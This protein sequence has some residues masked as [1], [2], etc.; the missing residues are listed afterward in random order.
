[1]KKYPRSYEFTCGI[2]LGLVTIPLIFLLEACFKE[3]DSFPH[4]KKWTFMFYDD[5]DF[6]PQY[7]RFYLFKSAMC[8][9]ENVNV[10]VLRDIHHGPARYY[11]ID[12]DHQH[13]LKKELGEIN[14]GSYSSLY[15]FLHY[16]KENYPAER[17]ILSLYNHGGGWIG[18]C[19]DFTDNHDWLS[20]DDMQI[21]LRKAGGVDLVFFSGVCLM[22]TVETAY[23]LRDCADAYVASENR[24]TYV[25]WYEPMRD[26]CHILNST[27]EISTFEFA[28]TVVDLI[29]NSGSEIL[30]FGQGLTMSAVRMDKM[31]DLIQGIDELSLKYLDNIGV[32]CSHISTVFRDVQVY[33]GE[34]IDL[35][36]LTQELLK[37]EKDTLIRNKLE[38]VQECLKEAVIAECH[39]DDMDGSHGLSIYFPASDST[40][41]NSFYNADDFS[42]DFARTSHWD[43]LLISYFGMIKRKIIKVI[44]EPPRTHLYE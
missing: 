43:E 22:A 2:I 7:D 11:Y 33:R 15:D 9:G 6:D 34:S 40:A 26:I 27:P 25:F 16:A 30:N 14:M 10:L 18:A 1:M 44:P 29:W 13:V 8:S 24:S 20:P 4:K 5:E 19:W 21:A 28:E 23:E 3:Q 39:G 32:F 31:D 37:V 17:Y 36:D 35:Y 12:E 41:Y 42:L 38:S